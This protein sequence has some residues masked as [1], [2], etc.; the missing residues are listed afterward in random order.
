MPRLTSA[1]HALLMLAASCAVAVSCRNGADD[2]PSSDAG[3]DSGFARTMLLDRS[4]FPQN[5]V[6]SPW[7][8]EAVDEFRSRSAWQHC[9]ENSTLPGETDRA[10]GGEYSNANT[11]LLSINP[12]VFVFDSEVKA[13]SGMDSLIEESEC[14]ARVIGNGLDVDEQFAFGETRVET[15]PEEMYNATS[16]IRLTNTQIYKT[17]VPPHTD[18][19]VFDVVYI[20][21]G[22]VVSEVTGFQ[23]YLPIDQ[24]LLREF[25]E[26]ARLKISQQP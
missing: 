21:D 15:L 25:I 14:F 8:Q 5:W 6:H 16:A 17:S 26:K 10:Y 23:R 11:T 2:R 13:E 1:P 12:A 4:D 3:S 24:E 22:R 9:Y 20:T 7:D 18:V 19:L